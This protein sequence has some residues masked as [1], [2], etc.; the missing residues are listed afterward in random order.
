LCRITF[1]FWLAGLIAI[2][3]N[4]RDRI[5]GVAIFSIGVVVSLAYM[6]LFTAPPYYYR[7]HKIDLL[8]SGKIL[9]FIKETKSAIYDSINTLITDNYYSV[10]QL[11]VLIGIAIITFFFNKNKLVLASLLVSLCLVGVMFAFYSMNEFYFTKQTAMLVPLL[12]VGLAI[13]INSSLAKYGLVLIL[14]WV[15]PITYKKTEDAIALGRQGYDHYNNNRALEKAFEEIPQHIQDEKTLILYC[16]REY[17]Y[18][19]SA[20]ALLPFS[21][22]AKQPI[23]YTTGIVD[24]SAEAERK[25]VLHN[26]MKVDYILSRHAISWPNL[27]QVHQTEFYHLYKL[28]E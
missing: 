18:G 19:T 20:E 28:I 27:K 5:I 23:M 4:K 16:Y 21:T 2:A 17:D 8:Y 12:I 22:R 9:S 6:K 15:F 3:E 24:P 26:K 14:I 13:T 10:K 11:L 1:I 7:M 25:F